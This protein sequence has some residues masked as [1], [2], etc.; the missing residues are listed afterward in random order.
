MEIVHLSYRGKQWE[1]ATRDTDFSSVAIG[2]RWQRGYADALR[3][4]ARAAW[5]QLAPLN[6]G[7]VVYEPD[8]QS[9]DS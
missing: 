5:L 6:T 9:D 7:V 2:E 8:E 3:V 1:T 4:I